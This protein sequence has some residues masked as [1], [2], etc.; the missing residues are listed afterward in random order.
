M[1]RNAMKMHTHV[2]PI[3]DGIIVGYQGVNT[4]AFS[5]YLIPLRYS[6]IN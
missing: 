5:Y 6:E 2:Y 4:G 1:K 3:F